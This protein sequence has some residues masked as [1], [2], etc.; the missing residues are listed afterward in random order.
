MPC[1]CPSLPNKQKRPWPAVLAWAAAA[2]VY[3]HY[4][5]TLFVI[6]VTLTAAW[7]SHTRG[8]DDQGTSRGSTL[9][10]PTVNWTRSRVRPPVKQA[11]P[12]PAGRTTARRGAPPH[13]TSPRPLSL[14]AAQ[15]SQ[16]PGRRAGHPLQAPR[17]LRSR[18][19][20][21]A[22][23]SPQSRDVRLAP[24]GGGAR[25]AAAAAVRGGHRAQLLWGVRVHPCGRWGGGRSLERSLFFFG[26]RGH[27]HQGGGGQRFAGGFAAPAGS[28][29]SAARARQFHPRFE[30]RR[31]RKT[32]G[33]RRTVLALLLR[34]V[35]VAGG[36]AS[37]GPRQLLFWG[38]ASPRSPGVWAGRAAVS[39]AGVAGARG[40]AALPTTTLRDQ[41]WPPKRRWGTFSSLGPTVLAPIFPISLY[42]S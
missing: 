1:L 4:P 13:P 38:R 33:G 25:R 9:K 18:S 37:L 12:A 41:K 32:R 22:R 7:A 10:H 2:N 27:M 3:A 19:P 35:G 23:A 20:A 11:A 30:R 15:R 17:D 29:G 5:S 24:A 16:P 31:P 14:A 26:G 8:C 39:A 36:V 34:V 21:G 40:T 28:L 42:D 6:C